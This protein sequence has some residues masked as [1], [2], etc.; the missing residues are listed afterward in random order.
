MKKIF[1]I[2]SYMIIISIAYASGNVEPP[3]TYVDLGNINI[4]L[5][6]RRYELLLPYEKPAGVTK[7]P[8]HISTGVIIHSLIVDGKIVRPKRQYFASNDAITRLYEEDVGV[9]KECRTL[10]F[11]WGTLEVNPDETVI[12][13]GVFCVTFPEKSIIPEQYNIPYGAKQVFLKYSIRYPLD[14]ISNNMSNINLDQEYVVRWTMEWPEV[15]T[16]E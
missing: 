16:R 6:K 1:T 10:E 5:G 15:A 4:V 11:L 12:K 3:A 9:E 14:V 7:V 8:N 13:K 2:L